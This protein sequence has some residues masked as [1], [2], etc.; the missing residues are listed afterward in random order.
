MTGQKGSPRPCAPA[1][2][3]PAPSRHT[4]R[5]FKRHRP[6][7]S[8]AAFFTPSELA[9]LHAPFPGVIRI[10]MHGSYPGQASAQH[11]PGHC[12]TPSLGALLSRQELRRQRVPAGTGGRA[13]RRSG[14]GRAASARSPPPP[15]ARSSGRAGRTPTCSASAASWARWITPIRMQT[16]NKHCASTL[17]Q[18]SYI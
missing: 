17:N 8:Q 11:M 18:F 14:R 3:C 7:Y 12:T 13:P 10:S 5:P 15:P 16:T 6:H 2:N 1:W 4:C 9:T